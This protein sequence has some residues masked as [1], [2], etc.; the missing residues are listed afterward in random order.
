LFKL[1]IRTEEM[2]LDSGRRELEPDEEVD[3][4]RSLRERIMHA[5]IGFIRGLI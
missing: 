4:K 1:W 3:P 5:P 2:D